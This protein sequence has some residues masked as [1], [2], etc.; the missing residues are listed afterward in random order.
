M[1]RPFVQKRPLA[2]HDPN[3][4]FGRPS[5]YKPEYCEQVMNHMAKGFS[6]S[7]FAGSIKQSR[8]TIYGWMG[9]HPEFSEAVSRGRAMRLVP[10]E[11]KLL[12]CEKGSEVAATIFALKNSDPE[13]WREV[14]YASF[15]HNV[16]IETL[17][18]EQLLAIASG[19]R[20]AAPVA[21]DVQYNRLIERP[22]RYE[23]PTKK[24][25]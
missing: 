25:K 16:K 3:Y 14:R 24:K 5:T 7:A 19:Q 9:K 21:I 6:L 10:W 4:V 11:E 12:K 22:R 1:V 20:D 18:D 2:H 23:D 15:D 17:S 13:E 8:E